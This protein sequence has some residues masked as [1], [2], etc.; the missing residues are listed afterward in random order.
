MAM[1]YC[2]GPLSV[3]ESNF[4]Y[5]ELFVLFVLWTDVDSPSWDSQT[6]LVLFLEADCPS[7]PSVCTVNKPQQ[8]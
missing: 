3:L 1:Y 7:G 5:F 6:N 8:L 4:E 2:C